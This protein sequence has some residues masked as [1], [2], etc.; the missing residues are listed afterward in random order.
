[1]VGRV[2]RFGFLLLFVG[3]WVSPGE[4]QRKV[5]ELDGPDTEPELHIV[6]I[7]PDY[8]PADG[9]VEVVI[10]LLET[11]EQ[12]VVYFSDVK[13]ALQDQSAKQV[14]VRSPAM[15]G[16]QLADVLV[17]C[18][19][20]RAL[21]ESAFKVFPDADGLVRST[22]E[23]SWI[24]H[25]GGYWKE[26]V[27]DYGFAI[28]Y[29]FEPMALDYSEFYGSD[30]DRCESG[31]SI[32]SVPIESMA[33]LTDSLTLSSS[34]RSLTLNYDS[35]MGYFEKSLQQSDYQRSVSYDLEPFGETPPWSVEAVDDFVET[36]AGELSI[37]NPPMDDI[38][39]PAVNREFD[40]TWP[41]AGQGDFVYVMIDRYRS[42][43]G[44]DFE[45]V[46]C[47]L[48]DDGHFRVS[49]SVFEGWSPG[50]YIM[51]RLGRGKRARGEFPQDGAGSG[52]VGVYWVRGAGYQD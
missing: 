14:V 5:N 40:L 19:N 12:P 15:Q 27:E 34:S 17:V 46:R 18:E 45:R 30:M 7:R 42:D 20:G 11:C 48:R 50:H 4:V 26:D 43:S 16:G 51:I 44:S 21:K 52:M 24:E 10:E 33:S 22:G 49:S 36:P 13:A 6:E 8:G 47:L 28:A 38:Y 32:G 1:M 3:C 9:G 37:T 2:V 39:L 23:F 31:Y 25:I 41:G 35:E 29:I